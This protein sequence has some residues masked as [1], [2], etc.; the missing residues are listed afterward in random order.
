MAMKFVSVD[1]TLSLVLARLKPA[2]VKINTRLAALESAS[3]GGT[4]DTV[5]TSLIT[6]ATA[7]TGTEFASGSFQL[8]K[9]KYLVTLTGRWSSNSSG[10]RQM[11]LTNTSG[12]STL[13]WNT[14]VSTRPPSGAITSVQLTALL[15]VSASTTFYVI[16]KQNSGNSLTLNVRLATLKIA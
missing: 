2:L 9:G 7:T 16:T 12:G 14:V 11:W 5:D 10:Y 8:A 15:D 4:I 3:G 13:R 1:E 6:D